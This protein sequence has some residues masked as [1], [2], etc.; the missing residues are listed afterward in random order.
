VGFANF[1]DMEFDII[2]A[3]IIFKT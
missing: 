1:V 2:D 3:N